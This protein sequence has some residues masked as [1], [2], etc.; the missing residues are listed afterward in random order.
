MS[1]LE[2][3]REDLEILKAATAIYERDYK[4]TDG[5]AVIGVVEAKIR[6][7]EA[8]A[9]DP[10]RDAKNAVEYFRG[11]AEYRSETDIVKLVD[12]LTAEVDRLTKENVALE[13]RIEAANREWAREN[14]ENHHL[15]EEIRKRGSK[16][17][18]ALERVAELERSAKASQV[19]LKR[20]D[21]IRVGDVVLGGGE[22]RTISEIHITSEGGRVRL[23]GKRWGE[24][25]IPC[26]L[27]AV[28]NGSVGGGE[29]RPLK[30]GCD[31]GK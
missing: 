23:W 18:K 12:H 28:V 1:E 7:L 26:D 19:S 16:L 6:K 20:A 27:V 22:I 5:R 29:T 25:F 14:A 4:G 30:K 15:M 3:L 17:K 21:E 9:A 2:Q 11:F 13:K 31:D 24:W 10:W 8:A